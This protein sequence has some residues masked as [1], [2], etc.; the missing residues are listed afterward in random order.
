MGN[1]TQSFPRLVKEMDKLASTLDEEVIMQIGHT[2][3]T[4]KNT[5]FFRFVGEQEMDSLILKA[6]LVVT[7]GGAGSILKCIRMGKTVIA[8]P[9]QKKFN[10]HIDDHQVELTEHLGEQK[11]II[12]VYEI[13]SLSE[14]IV[15][16]RGF[17]ASESSSSGNMV[18]AVRFYFGY[19][20][21]K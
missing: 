1:H 4:P 13:S 11:K 5:V 21:G 7:H 8:V 16:A 3:Y 17:K 12:P 14:A 18:D 19:L 9:R 20:L 10:E 2:H 6:T 15:T